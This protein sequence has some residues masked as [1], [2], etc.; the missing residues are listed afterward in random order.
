MS[1]IGEAD[2]K[3]EPEE[4]CDENDDQANCSGTRWIAICLTTVFMIYGF[5]CFFH[6]LFH[7]Y[8]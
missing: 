3:A 2:V 5:C 8:I 1:Q 7:D 4:F 6:N